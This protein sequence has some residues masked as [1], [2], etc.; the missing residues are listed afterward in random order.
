M[1]EHVDLLS[2]PLTPTTDEQRA[3]NRGYADGRESTLDGLNPVIERLQADLRAARSA[4]PSSKEAG[5]RTALR[6]LLSDFHQDPTDDYLDQ[7]AL[8]AIRA[9]TP[10]NAG[11]IDGL[12]ALSD[13]ATPGPWIVTPDTGSYGAEIAT[14][15][16]G[17]GVV[18]PDDGEPIEPG[19]P[20]A[21]AAFIVAAANYIRARLSESTGSEGPR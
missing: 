13:A 10:D 9:A 8:P 18:R 15:E 16:D 5:L 21:D 17:I 19:D 20:E 2:E 7:V 14:I 6:W 11:T 12:R 4:T 1:T 3:Y